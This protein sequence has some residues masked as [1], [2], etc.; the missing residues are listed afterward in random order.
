MAAKP[1]CWVQG[2]SDFTVITWKHLQGMQQSLFDSQAH[3]VQ[4]RR[5]CTKYET[6]DTE[7]RRNSEMACWTTT[8]TP[9]YPLPLPPRAVT[10]GL[11]GQQVKLS[12]CRYMRILAAHATARYII[13]VRFHSISLRRSSRSSHYIFHGSSTIWFCL[14]PSKSTGLQGWV[15]QW[16]NFLVSSLFQ[17]FR[18]CRVR[19][20]SR[21]KIAI[22]RNRKKNYFMNRTMRGRGGKRR[23]INYNMDPSCFP[24]HTS[25]VTLAIYITPPSLAQLKTCFNVD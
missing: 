10:H 16:S 14:P 15:P 25:Q 1:W 9:V 17:A 8:Y 7:A 18:R 21:E 23:W 20:E 22:K 12:S 3:V 19:V 2:L 6:F 4:G 5:L 11:R 24:L 13:C